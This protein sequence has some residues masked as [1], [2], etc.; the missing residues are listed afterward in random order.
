ML[1]IIEKGM[2]IMILNEM[3]YKLRTSAHLS[4]EEFA[5]MFN[6]SRQSVQK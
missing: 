6:V 1:N 2:V 3:I 5:S 4:Q